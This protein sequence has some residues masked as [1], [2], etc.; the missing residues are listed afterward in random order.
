[1]HSWCYVAEIRVGSAY[2]LNFQVIDDG[3]QYET[4]IV[5]NIWTAVDI[6]AYFEGQKND[7][8]V[9][10][11]SLTYVEEGWPDTRIETVMVP[12]LLTV[13]F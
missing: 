8:R 1:M 9:F 5:N 10:H 2:V 13:N 4:N 6:R 11:F 3:F 7:T 12:L